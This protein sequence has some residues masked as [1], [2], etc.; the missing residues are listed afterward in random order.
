MGRDIGLFPAI[1]ALNP[2]AG[3]ALAD[4]RKAIQTAEPL[5][6]KY[7][8]DRKDAALDAAK[9]PEGHRAPAA[10]SKPSLTDIFRLGGGQ[11]GQLGVSSD[12]AKQ[13][14]T[15]RNDVYEVIAQLK[16]AEEAKGISADEKKQ[17]KSL[18][19]QLGHTVRASE[20]AIKALHGASA[21]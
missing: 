5:I 14:S 20:F 16:H 18:T 11:D 6:Q 13:R 21:G 1:F 2:M 19:K 10:T 9:T 7:G 3:K 4:L 12:T 8:D 17:V 15:V